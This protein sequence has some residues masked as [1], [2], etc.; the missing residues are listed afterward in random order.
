MRSQ[1]FVKQPGRLEALTPQQKQ[2][3]LKVR[4]DF[5]VFTG[6]EPGMDFP[7]ATTLCRFRKERG[8]RGQSPS[9]T[10]GGLSRLRR[11]LLESLG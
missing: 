11:S 10:G 9:P 8:I 7:D 6:F 1:D 3:A 4:I 5:M 2:L